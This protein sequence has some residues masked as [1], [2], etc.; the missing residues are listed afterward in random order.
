MMR[1][2]KLWLFGLVTALFVLN[3]CTKDFDDINTNTQGFLTDEVSAKFFLTSSQVGL[4]APDRFVYWRAHLIH[5]DRF[6][7]HFT[8]GH[9][10]SWWSDGLC[11]NFN[12][13][14]TDATY[15]WLAGYFGNIKSFA[16][17]TAEGGEFENEYMYAMSLIMK[18]LYYQMYTDTF[19]MVPYTEAGV[20][21]I[22]TPAYDTQATIYKGI[23]ADLDQA[24]SIIGDTE[25]TGLGVNDAG[26]NDIYCGGDLQQW[27][28]LANTL[29]LRIGM[30]ALGAPGDDFAA[31]TITSAMGA[32][33]LD[34][35]SGSVTMIKDFE[36]SKWASAAYG[37]VWNDFGGGS[38]WTVSSTLINLL[39]DN[40]DPRLTAYVQPAKGGSFEFD[41]AASDPPDPNF[42]DRLDFIVANLDA[43]GANYNMSTSGTVTTIEVGSGQFI[44]QPVRVNG[45][46]YS[47]M[48]YDM[49]ST[50]SEDVITP[51]GKQV[52]GYPEIILSSAEAYFLQAE[53]V[54]RGLAA[55]DAQALMNSGIEEAMK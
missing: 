35:A 4:Y 29:K 47:F 20:D 24:M 25:R 31:A 1:K 27:K 3:S 49:F 37:D 32:P 54:V 15:N 11:Y 8:F 23:I 33:L 52:D 18:G 7:G 10:S 14:Y 43:A 39:K 12:A 34:A 42:Q 5:S 30:R 2:N 17:L 46:T 36:I 55:G 9:N 51:R 45:D 40:N 22:L 28:R 26:S 41:S 50:P 38:D 19:G 48:R 53:A 6:A 44:G 16:D 13:S 21:G